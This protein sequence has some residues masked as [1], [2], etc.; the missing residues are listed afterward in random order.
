MQKLQ[1]TDNETVLFTKMVRKINFFASMNMGLLEKILNW[2]A[3]YQ[4]GK[5]EKVCRQ[6]EPGD[7]LYVLAEGRLSVNV[8]GGFFS[9]SKKVAELGPGSI[10]GEM[11]LLTR[12]PRTA[13]LVCEEPSKVFVLLA[14]HF[15]EA[16]RQN[17]AFA[18]QIKK[19]AADRKFELSHK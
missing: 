17:P 6:G 5:G 12:E 7:S 10:L 9:F 15:D 11:S 3:Y 13:T 14:D 18:E 8:K 16:L 4:F 19:L 1:V 2:I